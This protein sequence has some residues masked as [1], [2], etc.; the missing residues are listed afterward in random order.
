TL[1]FSVLSFISCR[2]KNCD[3]SISFPQPEIFLKK[4]DGRGCPVFE[5]TDGIQALQMLDQL[6]IYLAVV[7]LFLPGKDGIEIAKEIG[8]KSPMTHLLLLTV[9]GDHER[10]LEARRIFG[11]NFFN[12][13]QVSDHL[14]NRV[15]EILGERNLIDEA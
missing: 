9:Y 6:S 13:K 11:S 14:V 4:S 12:K 8:R 5:A 10:A 1:I 15:Q 3:Y 2:Q 7:D